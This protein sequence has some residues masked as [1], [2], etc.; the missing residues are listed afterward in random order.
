MSK[1][2][3]IGL[4]ILAVLLLIQ[5]IRREKNQSTESFAAT[6]YISQEQPPAAVS[7]ILKDAC[8]DCHSNHSAYPWYSEVAPV[9]WWITSHI[10]GGKQHLN[11]HE[12]GNYSAKKA[13]HKLEECHEMIEKKSMPLKSYTWLHPEAKLTEEQRVMLVDYFKAAEAKVRAGM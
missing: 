7:K 6:D 11:F 10:N 8:Y 4:G 2:K 1:R 9:S 3:K 12:Y 13:A 5:V